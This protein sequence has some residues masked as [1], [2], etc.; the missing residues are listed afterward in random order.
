MGDAMFPKNQLHPDAV[1][2]A[3]TGPVQWLW[4][5][6]S[7]N[8]FILSLITHK[9]WNKYIHHEIIKYVAK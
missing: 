6:D 8:Y 9:P 3:N 5:V 2:G 1:G 7:K 4:W